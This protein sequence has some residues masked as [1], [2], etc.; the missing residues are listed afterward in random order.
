MPELDPNAAGE[1]GVV[2]A[3]ALDGRGG[4]RNLAP[5]EVHSRQEAVWVH[6]DRGA[7]DTRRW[8]SD[9]EHIELVVAEALL[10]DESRPRVSVFGE[11]MLIN[12]RG[13]NLNPGSEPDDMV[14]L[15]LWIEPGRV[16]TVRRR[17]LMAVAR[18]RETLAAGEGP[19]T[20]ADL[21]LAVLQQLLELTGPVIERIE[22]TIDEIDER[23][24]AGEV[25]GVTSELVDARRKAV[26]LRRYL[27]PQRDATARLAGES[28]RLFDEDVRVRLRENAD[29][30]MRLTEDLDSVR[31][32]AALTQEQVTS[33]NAE[34]LNR[35]MYLLA[36]V[37]AV[38]L[39]L[40]LI[41]GLFGINVGGIPMAE[42]ETGFRMMV[43]ALAAT[44]AG[45]IALFKALGL[46]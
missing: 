37:T 33:R 4:A 13:V 24:L 16:I 14:S 45:E 18:I 2:F 6:L 44:T 3:I 12:L 43:V 11:G 9:D 39:P 27:A 8:L 30:M 19:A 31:E 1:G 32:R 38:F 17:R 35:R 10:A 15:R 40:G 23:V 22:D 34:T 21:V 36:I 41:T 5:G 28:H 46:L 42:S 26:R 7:E 25:A 29:R 20:L